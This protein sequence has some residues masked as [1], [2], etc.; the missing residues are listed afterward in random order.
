MVLLIFW[1][2][3]SGEG[4]EVVGEFSDHASI[5]FQKVDPEMSENL[6]AISAQAVPSDIL[7]KSALFFRRLII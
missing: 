7:G 1:P 5:I 4:S 3:L 2:K 6:F